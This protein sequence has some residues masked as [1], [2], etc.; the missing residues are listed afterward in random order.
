MEGGWAILL[1]CGALQPVLSIQQTLSGLQFKTVVVSRNR[2]NK[3]GFEASLAKNDVLPRLSLETPGPAYISEDQAVA[4]D[5]I[6]SINGVNTIL[7]STNKAGR[8]H[9]VQLPCCLT[10]ALVCRC[11]TLSRKP[12]TKSTLSSART[13]LAS[14][15]P[16]SRSAR[17]ALA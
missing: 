9:V 8:G 13:C 6:I 16:P 1:T 14:G 3:F 17:V 12:K 10:L 2:A 5:G 7:E 11:A 4:G 15:L